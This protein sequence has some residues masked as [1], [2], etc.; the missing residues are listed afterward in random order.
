MHN[1]QNAQN[2]QCESIIQS[3]NQ[4][5][6]MIDVVENFSFPWQSANYQETFRI[7]RRKKKNPYGFQFTKNMSES[8]FSE[9]HSINAQSP[10]QVEQ[11]VL[12]RIGSLAGYALI[13]YLVIEMV[14]D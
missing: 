7:W 5:I 14:V 13:F 4:G 2:E 9:S 3:I 10:S 6:N 1:E 8:E 12:H 11:D